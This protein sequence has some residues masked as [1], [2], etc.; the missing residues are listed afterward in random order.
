MLA[1]MLA[2]CHA[3]PMTPSTARKLALTA[4]LAGTV[5]LTGACG[6]SADTSMTCRIDDSVITCA[7]T[8]APSGSPIIGVEEDGSAPYADGSSY[9]A[10]TGWQG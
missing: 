7:P 8:L 10:E 3:L 9:D 6:N 2:Y 1:L 4:L 5:A